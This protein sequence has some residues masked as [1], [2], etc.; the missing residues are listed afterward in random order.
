MTDCICIFWYLIDKHCSG[1]SVYCNKAEMTKS[2][3]DVMYVPEN[4]DTGDNTKCY[5][6]NQMFTVQENLNYYLNR[7]MGRFC[8]IIPVDY[9]DIKEIY[10]KS[11]G[12]FEYP[13][14]IKNAKV[15][16]TRV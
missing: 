16:V 1:Y 9:L 4:F 5:S 14:N 8:I 7:V 6:F 3:Y 2:K 13:E 15:V 12:F 11:F 10:E